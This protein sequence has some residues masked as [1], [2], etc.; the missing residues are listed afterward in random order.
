MS[1]ESAPHECPLCGFRFRESEGCGTCPMGAGCGHLKCPNCRYE[2]VASSKT[3][4][5]L[6]GL[7]RRFFRKEQ[8]P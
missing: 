1:E 3:V 2:F 7:F 6:R 4:E 8:G 5:L